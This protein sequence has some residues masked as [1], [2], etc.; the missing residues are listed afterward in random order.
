MKSWDLSYEDFEKYIKEAD[1]IVKELKA[2]GH[3]RRGP[4]NISAGPSKPISVSTISHDPYALAKENAAYPFLSANQFTR[5]KPFVLI[6]VVHPWLN[7]LSLDSDFANAGTTFTR[8][9][10]R[11]AFMQFSDDKTLARDYCKQISDKTTLGDASRLLSAIM[12]VNVWP[13]DAYRPGRSESNPKPSWIYLNPRAT[14]KIP[15]GQMRVFQ[16]NLATYIDDFSND[17]Y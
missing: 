10:A 8:A 4:M 12:F 3:T 14:N 1:T 6:Y 11:R 9:F 15:H 5:N 13:S 2:K 17:D 16:N 7:H